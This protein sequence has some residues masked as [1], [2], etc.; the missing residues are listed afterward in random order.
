MSNFLK[1]CV[2]KHS[3]AAAEEIELLEAHL[4]PCSTFFLAVRITPETEA[5]HFKQPTI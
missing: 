3:H 5:F 1:G 2:Q 4:N